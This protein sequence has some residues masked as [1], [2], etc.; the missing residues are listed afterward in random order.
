M[1]G[2][3]DINVAFYQGDAQTFGLFTAAH[4]DWLRG[5]VQSAGGGEVITA[6]HHSLLAHTEFSR[7]SYLMLT[8]PGGVSGHEPGMAHPA[9]STNYLFPV[10]APSPPVL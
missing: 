7:D 10:D 3:H 9:Y 2:K 4:A 6:A 1:P 5:V 8:S